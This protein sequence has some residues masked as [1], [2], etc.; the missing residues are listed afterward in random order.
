M[1]AVTVTVP[2]PPIVNSG[3][4]VG[5]RVTA[6]VANGAPSRRSLV[7][8]LPALPPIPPLTGPRVSSTASSVLT[9]TVTVAVSQLAGLTTSHRL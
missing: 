7:S 1:P 8:T 6:V 3:L 2:S 9:A 5:V 4:F